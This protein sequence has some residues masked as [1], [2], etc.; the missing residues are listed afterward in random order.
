V[1]FKTN[2]VIMMGCLCSFGEKKERNKKDM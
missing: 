2:G 1:F